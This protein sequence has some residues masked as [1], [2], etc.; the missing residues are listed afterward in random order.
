MS[1]LPAVS[2]I[3]ALMPEELAPHILLDLSR[4]APNSMDRGRLHLG[5]YCN[6]FD[7]DIH[8]PV[9]SHDQR[10][11]TRRALVEAW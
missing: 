9:R 1:T 5:N 10:E 2:E 7:A 3:A 4:I 6:Q 11:N 8:G